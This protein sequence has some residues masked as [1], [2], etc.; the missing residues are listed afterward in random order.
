MPPPHLVRPRPTTR[1]AELDGSAETP[2][3]SSQKHSGTT[4]GL[5][6]SGIVFS[7]LVSIAGVLCC[8]AKKLGTVKPWATGLSGQLQKAFVTG[9]LYSY[10][11]TSVVLYPS[12]YVGHFR[13]RHGNLREMKKV[14]DDRYNRD[15][16]GRKKVAF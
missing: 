2:A 12:H 10:S 7:L 3:H 5:V 4:Y 1:Q 6:A 15:V 16:L 9:M 13:C 8:R 14:D 11:C